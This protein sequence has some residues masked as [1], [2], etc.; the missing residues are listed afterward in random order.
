MVNLGKVLSSTS[1][2]KI[3]NLN[4]NK[5]PISVVADNFEVRN[6]KSVKIKENNSIKFKLLYDRHN[7]LTKKIKLE[8]LKKMW[9]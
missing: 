5:R 4:T 7:S 8:Y 1:E 9:N 3:K 6:V 2:I